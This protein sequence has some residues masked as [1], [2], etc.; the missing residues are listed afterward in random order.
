MTAGYERGLTEIA[1]GVWAMA[2]QG[3]LNL[4]TNAQS[5]SAPPNK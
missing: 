1:D 5:S 3:R 4:T 2:H